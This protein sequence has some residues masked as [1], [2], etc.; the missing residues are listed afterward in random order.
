MNPDAN[1]A[2]A[3]DSSNV[4]PPA[5]PTGNVTTTQGEGTQTAGGEGAQS[6]DSGA[7]LEGLTPELVKYINGQGGIAK[8]VEASKQYRLDNANK[9]TT[10]SSQVSNILSAQQAEVTA[11]TQ[12]AQP[13]Q[14]E[15]TQ[16]TGQIGEDYLT[17][18]QM[19]TIGLLNVMANK[20]PEV[21]SKLQDASILKEA[22]DVFKVPVFDGQGNLNYRLIDTYANQ[23]N[24]IALAE[25]SVSSAPTV[26]QP[27]AKVQSLSE[28][29]SI[30][31][32]TMNRNT[33]MNIVLASNAAEKKG[34]AKHP[35]FDRAIRVL[36]TGKDA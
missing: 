36:Q 33:A 30:P 18:T 6:P 7:S 31:A 3:V 17:P 34:E 24:K 20:Y 22:Q 29:S 11:N 23:L 12:P 35:D 26:K 2:A 21:A 13:K 5:N 8:F 25:K 28:M 32:G 27:E 10:E 19:S 16:P 4:T 9:A 14:P 1:N 15:V